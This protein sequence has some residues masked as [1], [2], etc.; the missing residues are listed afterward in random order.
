MVRSL[1]L[2][3]ALISALAVASTPKQINVPVGHTTTLSMPSPVSA[4]K[5]DDPALV[6]VKKDGRKVSFVARSQGNTHATVMTSDGE[7]RFRIYVAA[8]KYALPY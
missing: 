4:V 8:D 1:T 7:V 2:V 6:E 5:V 3:S